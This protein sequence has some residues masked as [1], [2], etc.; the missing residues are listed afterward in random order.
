MVYL[1][2]VV[3]TGHSIKQRMWWIGTK[4]QSSCSGQLKEF[5]EPGGLIN[6]TEASCF[7]VEISSTTPTYHHFL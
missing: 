2:P 3:V 7:S 6:F 5:G 4:Q 1:H